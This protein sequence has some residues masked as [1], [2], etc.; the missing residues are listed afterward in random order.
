MISTAASTFLPI[1]TVDEHRLS[2]S[3]GYAFDYR[4]L[5]PYESIVSILWKFVRV[6]ALAGHVVAAEVGRQAVDPYEGTE[7]HREAI[8]ITRLQRTLG[9]SRD[10][11]R[12]A[13]IPAV[14]YG[15]V[16]SCLR[17]CP[18][19]LARGY[20]AVVHQFESVGRCP[21]HDLRLERACRQCGHVAPYRLN[22]GLLETPYRCAQCRCLYGTGWPRV[23][24]RSRM[25]MKELIPMTRTHIARC[26]Y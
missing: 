20:H 14:R 4:W 10:V 1:L 23:P 21:I 16:S 12:K 15:A 24:G 3:F 11:L 13:L 6:N 25:P 26:R 8:D 2:P 9:V 22:A 19:C 17:Y 18:R 5:E 7:S